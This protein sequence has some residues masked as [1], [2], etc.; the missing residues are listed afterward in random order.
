[1]QGRIA[2]LRRALRSGH[3]A[4]EEERGRE[5]EREGEKEK[6]N[7]YLCTTIQ[8][9]VEMFN[10]HIDL[11]CYVVIDNSAA[12]ILLTIFRVFVFTGL[13]YWTGL[14]DWTT[15]LDYWTGLLD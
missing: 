11:K 13:D 3:L 9:T 6:T 1:M 4:T 8:Y 14:L 5:R 2:N 12:S 10:L 7:K 15:G